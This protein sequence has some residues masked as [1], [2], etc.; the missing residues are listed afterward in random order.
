ME[1]C[2]LVA[3]LEGAAPWAGDAALAYA[4]LGA[5][6]FP[7]S[8]DTKQPL[9]KSGFKAASTNPA[10]VTNWWREWP[11]A[12]IGMPTGRASGVLVIDIDAASETEACEQLQRLRDRLGT[13]PACPV[14]RT[15]SGGMHL[16]FDWAPETALGNRTNILRAAKGAKG[17]DVRGEGGYVILPPSQ[18]RDG[19]IYL[20]QDGCGLSDLG[21]PA[22]PPELADLILR[23]DP[24]LEAAPIDR[25][26]APLADRA[27]GDRERRYALAAFDAEIRKVEKAGKGERN[28]TL[29]T[30][31]FSLGQLI[32]AGSLSE[33]VVRAA[34]ERAAEAC[35]LVKDDGRHSVQKSISSGLKDGMAQPRDLAPQRRQDR[36]AEP[37]PCRP[38]ANAS[39]KMMQAADVSPSE[40]PAS[41]LRQV[42]RIRPGLLHEAVDHAEEILVEA[43]PGPIFQRGRDL[44]H[45]TRSRALRSDGNHELQAAIGMADHA[46]F[47]RELACAARYERY[48]ARENKWVPCD[49]PA[50]LA[51]QYWG[52]PERK[53]AP[54]R[55]ILATP[56]LRPDGSLLSEPGY[57]V[58]TGLY[59]TAA[60]PGLNVPV[61]PTR[62]DAETAYEMLTDLLKGFCFADPE[63][64]EGQSQAVAMAGLLT[65]V[66]RPVLPAAPLTAVTAPIQGS[67]KS[68]L[69][70]VIA[71]IAT[72]QRAACVATG[73]DLQEMEKSLAAELMEGRALLLLD[74]LMQPLQGQFLAMVLTQETVKVRVLG[75]SK[76]A[77]PSTGVAMFATGNNLQIKGD[78]PRRTL[79][80]RLDPRTEKPEHLTY[81]RDLLAE[82][83]HHRA[84]LL[85][86]ALTIGCWWR[87]ARYGDAWHPLE[88]AVAAQPLAGFSLWCD[89][90]RDPLVA[91]GAADPVQTIAGV[92]A[93][94]EDEE[95]HSAFLKAWHDQHGSQI[96]TC[97]EIIET[98]RGELYD[99]L[100]MVTEDRSSIRKLAARLK[101]I[102]GRFYDNHCL[103]KPARSKHGSTWRVVKMNDTI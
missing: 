57:D 78:L 26:S 48:A 82:V 10:E 43:G 90:V 35:G 16:W 61:R 85:S 69:V 7:C 14:V 29:N 70:D 63:G 67:G 65:A 24:Q 99:L 64:C 19:A 72:G 97:K 13:L 89:W 8:A 15:P 28:A 17:I 75:L 74:N 34:L 38:V 31:A 39:D 94:D 30:A 80:C 46:L 50:K 25:N 22:L 77:A 66:L 32:A 52:L 51:E 27:T 21:P 100:N 5:P 71:M 18:R 47:L 56:T 36:P 73:G 53:L 9:T 6:I 84:E 92:R 1:L 4:R 60:V 12:M 96:K 33:T 41:D 79:L 88:S 23:R 87:T 40:S 45:I 98:A 83:R 102:A 68:Y 101:H 37:R 93:S 44:V 42:I 62:E 11:R 2:A 76:M 59:L 95:L 91:L 49:P 58:A 55:Q 20:W 3:R 103:E 81:D 86:A 54:L